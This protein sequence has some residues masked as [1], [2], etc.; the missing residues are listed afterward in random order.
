MGYL[1]NGEL[2]I[3]QRAEAWLSRLSQ[4]GRG[5]SNDAAVQPP[6]GCHNEDQAA[7]PCVEMV[8]EGRRMKRQRLY[9]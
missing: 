9:R 6:E 1:V 8:A 5:L 3:W 2:Q 4:E 7:S